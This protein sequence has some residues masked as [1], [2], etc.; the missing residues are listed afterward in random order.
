MG[1]LWN[2]IRMKYQKIVEKGGEREK[3]KKLELS[4]EKRRK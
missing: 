1:E 2:I 4:L 3:R